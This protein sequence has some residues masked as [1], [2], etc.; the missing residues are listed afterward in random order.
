MYDPFANGIALALV[1]V[2]YIIVQA[3]LFVGISYF[4]VDFYHGA[5]EFL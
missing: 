5:E 4:M 3:V 2:P 1:E